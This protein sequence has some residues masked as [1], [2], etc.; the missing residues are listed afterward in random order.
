MARSPARNKRPPLSE[1]QLRDL[2]L[3]YVGRFATTRARLATYLARK[4]RERGWE[5]DTPPDIDAI[6]T[7]MT[8]LQYIDD[9]QY[10]V[11]KGAAMARR[12]LGP[13]R[14]RA[15][16]QADGIDEVDR[17]GAEAQARID[18]WDAA[19]TLA[20]RKR[21]GPYATALADPAQ[22]QKQIA[23][24]ARSGHDF[25]TA[26]RWVDAAPGEIPERDEG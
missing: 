11:M 15:G 25:A 5:G 23:M 20:R 16:L 17:Q 13:R 1:G 18:A 2:A 3:H 21:V 6:V 22:R 7:R 26:C 24:F 19:E 12:G 9:A 4:V 8:D 10:G 14:I